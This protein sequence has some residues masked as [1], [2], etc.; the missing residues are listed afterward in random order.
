MDFNEH[1]GFSYDDYLK[2]EELRSGTIRLLTDIDEFSAE[3]L[4]TEIAYLARHK[5]L[6]ITIIMSSPGGDAYHA[7]A[8][9]DAIRALCKTGTEVTILVEGMAAS[10]AAMII[11]QAAS[12]RQARPNARLLLHEVRRWVFAMERKS[13]V[14]DEYREMEAVTDQIV[15]IL[16]ERCQKDPTEVKK[17]IERKEVWMSAQEALAWGLIDSVT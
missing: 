6:E 15:Q 2:L 1:S 5:Y 3:G 10:A 7:F 9:Y 16:S 4:L 12:K 13:D 8:M 17:L 11:L 14:Q